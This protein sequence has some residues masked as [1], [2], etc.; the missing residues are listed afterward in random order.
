M[1]F[2][3]EKKV[4]IPF[5]GPLFVRYL[6]MY[7]KHHTVNYCLLTLLI[8]KSLLFIH[9]FSSALLSPLLLRPSAAVAIPT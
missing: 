2:I 3:H 6:F 7:F 5:S 9:L 4:L 1:T 8:E